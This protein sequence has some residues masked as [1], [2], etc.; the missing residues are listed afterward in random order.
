MN[1]VILIGH[2]GSDIEL[3]EANGTPVVNFTLAT[4]ETYK[5]KDGKYQTLTEWH[6]LTAW[7][8]TAENIVKALGK[9]D[10]VSIEGKNKTTETQAN[11][12]TYKNTVV[13]VSIFNRLNDKDK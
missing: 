13:E 4:N 6:Q 1:K 3:K 12:T 8:Q 7:R 5:D 11:E 2:I 9:G 10:L